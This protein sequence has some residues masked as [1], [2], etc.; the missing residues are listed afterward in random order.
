ML[1]STRDKVF[2]PKRKEDKTGLI[3]DL[4]LGRNG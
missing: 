3:A 1:H 4:T 2:S